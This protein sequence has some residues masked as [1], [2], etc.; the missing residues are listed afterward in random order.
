MS[1]F[2]PP[3][4]SSAYSPIAANT[5]A[6][7]ST[8]QRNPPTGRIAAIDILRALVMLLMLVDHVRE[9][10]FYHQQVTDP[11]DLDSTSPALFF[12]RLAAHFCAPV[13]VF[14]TGVS[15]WLYAH[16][17]HQPPRSASAFLL[18]RGLFIIGIEIAVINWLWMGS[19]DTLWLQVMWAIGV[20]MLLLGILCRLPWLILLCLGITIVAGHNLLDP[21]SFTPGQRG[22]TLWTILHDPGF[23]YTSEGFAIKASYPVLPWIGVILLGYS[24]GRMY[25]QTVSSALRQR[26]LIGLA[27]ALWLLLGLLRTRLGYG[28]A[29]S[30]TGHADWLY[31]VMQF[32]NYTK[33]PPSLDF[34]LFT[35]GGA[36]LL[37]GLLENVN[38]RFS[39]GIEI[40]GAAPMFFYILH[41]GVLLMSY[42]LALAV[43][44][45]NY[46]QWFAFDHVWQIWLCA[47]LMGA[48]LYWPTRAFSRYKRRSK[49]A[50]IKYF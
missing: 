14:L 26:V 3:I 30:F 9:R 38:N 16:P 18:K 34:V 20:S 37:L 36:L 23:I 40:F 47:G 29:L 33:Y 31:N 45:A 39:W 7:A 10:F 49:H 43:F 32:V 24:L 22:Y 8:I 15:A 11:M 6:G 2:A 46:G 21:I 42:Q 13:F 44:G 27:V 1:S 5:G 41:L 4:L 25:A 28:E 35:L 50:L 48:G 17:A 19:Y 12:T